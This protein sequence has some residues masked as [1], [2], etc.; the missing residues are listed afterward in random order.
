MVI[1]IDISVVNDEVALEEIEHYPVNM[2]EVTTHPNIRIGNFT[3]I[4]IIS[5]DGEQLDIS[6]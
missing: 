3:T 2:F 4:E 5:E 6:I 1:D